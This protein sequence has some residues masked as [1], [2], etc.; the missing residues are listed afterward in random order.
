MIIALNCAGRMSS[1]QYGKQNADDFIAFGMEL[2]NFRCVRQ[3]SRFD[4]TQPQAR[5][6]GFF[7][8]DADL[9][10]KIASAFCAIGF[11][12]VGGD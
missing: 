5:F 2:V 3:D 4:H 1:T 9:V 7:V 8:G 11:F 12:H 10:D 6:T